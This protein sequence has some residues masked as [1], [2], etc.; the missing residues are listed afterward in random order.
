MKAHEKAFAEIKNYYN[1]ITHNNLD[2]IRSLKEEVSFLRLSKLL[3]PCFDPI[4][5]LEEESRL[6]VYLSIFFS[7]STSSRTLQKRLGYS[8]RPAFP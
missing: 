4:R 3:L 7:F 5:S 1:D 2:L 8:L 6:C